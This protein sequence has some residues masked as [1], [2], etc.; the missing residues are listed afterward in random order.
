MAVRFWRDDVIQ[1]IELC[2][3]PLA[4]SYPGN[5]FGSISR[6]LSFVSVGPNLVSVSGCP[7]AVLQ[8]LDRSDLFKF[9]LQYPFRFEVLSL[10]KLKH[11]KYECFFGKIDIFSQV[12]YLTVFLVNGLSQT[13]MLDCPN[14]ST[15]S[16][17]S[18][19]LLST[20]Q[21]VVQVKE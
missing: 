1:R 14:L 12:K 18:S 20:E 9:S 17:F 11:Q 19:Y 8:T 3:H 13:W 15:V 10:P 5:F 2:R 6:L 21:L 16:I 4:S 7:S